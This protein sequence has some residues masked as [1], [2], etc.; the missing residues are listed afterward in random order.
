MGFD[1]SSQ[2]SFSACLARVVE[3]DALQGSRSDVDAVMT[4]AAAVAGA[5]LVVLAS[6]PKA[7]SSTLL[8]PLFIYERLLGGAG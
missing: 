7:S 2:P 6:P 4:S 1:Y 8:L 5:V 3:E